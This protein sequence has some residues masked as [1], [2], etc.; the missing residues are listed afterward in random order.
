MLQLT[1]TALKKV[2]RDFEKEP[3]MPF[4]RIFVSPG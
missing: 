2:T 4:A 1:D 3:E